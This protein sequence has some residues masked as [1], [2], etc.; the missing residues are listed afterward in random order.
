MILIADSGST[1]T[2]WRLVTPSGK[3]SEQSSRGFNPFFHDSDS[4]E[5]AIYEDFDD[6]FEKSEIKKIFFWL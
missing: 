6:T 5:K 3:T 4:I 2:D 1:K